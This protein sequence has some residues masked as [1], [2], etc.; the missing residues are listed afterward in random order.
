MTRFAWL[1]ERPQSSFPRV[2]WF[3]LLQYPQSHDKKGIWTTEATYALQFAR[4]ED[5]ESFMRLEINDFVCCVATEHGF[6]TA[7]LIT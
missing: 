3:R 5:A 4:R 7:P 6:A 2:E 1:I